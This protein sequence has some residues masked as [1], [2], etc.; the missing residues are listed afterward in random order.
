MTFVDLQPTARRMSELVSRVDADLDAPTPCGDYTLGAL[1]D[2]ID[3]FTL[4]FTAAAM[5]SSGAAAS[6]SP[7]GD[8]ARLADDWQARIPRDLVLLTEAWRD[9]TA[10]TGMTRAGGVDLPGEIAP[11]VALEEL[12]IH[13]WD[14]ARATG[15]SYECDDATL[16]IV[17]G[18]VSQFAG[19]DQADMRGSAYRAPVA[20][21]DTAPL[22]DRVVALSGRDPA[23][24]PR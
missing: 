24:S 4:G 1:L 2:H 19:D 17:R 9:P 6:E 5:K 22:L 11:V 23:W 20:V 10:R 16:E 13:G 15:Q 21:G 8:A 18:F 12:V 3:R 14:L 7:L